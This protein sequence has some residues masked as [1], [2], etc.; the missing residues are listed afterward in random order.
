[1]VTSQQIQDSGKKRMKMMELF[2]IDSNKYGGPFGMIQH[3][4]AT[5][6]NSALSIIIYHFDYH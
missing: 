3:F 2:T 5:Y 4:R 6:D 1:M